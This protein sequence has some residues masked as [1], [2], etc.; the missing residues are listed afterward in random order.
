MHDHFC[1]F[2][3]KHGATWLALMALLFGACS[4]SGTTR[5]RGDAGTHDGGEVLD[6]V[7]CERAVAH[8]CKLSC[9]CSASG[10]CVTN[11]RVPVGSEYIGFV[12][13]DEQDCAVAYRSSWCRADE[14]APASI[15][16]CADAVA[17]LTCDCDD[18]GSCVGKA[19]A[20][21]PRECESREL[22]PER[23]VCRS[24]ADCPDSHCIKGGILGSSV[25]DLQP[26]EEGVCA[27]E[28]QRWEGGRAMCGPQCSPSEGKFCGK[29]WSCVNSECRCVLLEGDGGAPDE[30]C[31]GLDNDCNG[32]VDDPAQAD[33][34][35]T[36]RFG[37]GSLCERGACRDSRV[38]APST[39]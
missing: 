3:T 30:V 22:T 2:S 9:E 1:A 10:R 37:E 23:T 12:W 13:S 28:C 7:S 18:A 35:C 15:E 36:A 17:A 16:A 38:S 5:G 39:P 20:V 27:R 6:P 24:D 21:Q 14:R 33:A 31:D 4:S 32:V 19:G 11:H 26:T 8:F 34:F 25:L 29:G